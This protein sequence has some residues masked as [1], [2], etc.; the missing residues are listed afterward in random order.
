MASSRP[1]HKFTSLVDDGEFLQHEYPNVF[2][3]EERR[4][5]VAP[6]SQH[7]NLLSSL[8][9]QI[10]PP[11]RIR[12]VL[13]VASA[14]F[15]A[16]RYDLEDPLSKEDLAQFLRRFQPFLENDGRHH[17]WVRSLDGQSAVVY[18]QHDLLYAYGTLEAYESVCV[19]EGLA[20]GTIEV[21]F[22]HA[23]AFIDEHDQD[24]RELL[25]EW[26]WTRSELVDEVDFV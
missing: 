8:I 18:D 21:P 20:P 1:E 5:V 24:L 11:Y 3:R 17:F 4:L 25:S 7:V 13:Q 22:P 15:A 16:G 26:Q 10:E 2:S 9:E 14:G 23:H 19:R 6:R 12:Y